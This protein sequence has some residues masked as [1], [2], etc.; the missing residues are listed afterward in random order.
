MVTWNHTPMRRQHLLRHK[1]MFTEAYHFLNSQ[2][3]LCFFVLEILLE[4]PHGKFS[5]AC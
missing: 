4:T 1:R 2:V 3:H 5:E